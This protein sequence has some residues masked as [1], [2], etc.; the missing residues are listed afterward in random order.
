MKK[1]V[2]ALLLLPLSL[3]S[4]EFLRNA[5]KCEPVDAKEKYLKC[6]NDKFYKLEQKSFN[7]PVVMYETDINDSKMYKQVTIESNTTPSK[8]SSGISK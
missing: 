7:E 6:N 4:T 2:L 1:L 8:S 3:H 5:I